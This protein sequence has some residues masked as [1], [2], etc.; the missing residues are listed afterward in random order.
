MAKIKWLK[1][2]PM[3]LQIL[4][5]G[6][7]IAVLLQTLTL[8]DVLLV[9]TWVF[10]TIYFFV[11]GLILLV[12]AVWKHYLNSSAYKHFGFK[13]GINVVSI[14]LGGYLIASGFLGANLISAELAPNILEFFKQ[15]SLVANVSAGLLI[16]YHFFTK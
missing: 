12:E 10:P 15:T 4:A 7:L 5:V 6:A 14:L 13:D 2:N 11:V 8:L 3:S 1:V 16:I 9:S